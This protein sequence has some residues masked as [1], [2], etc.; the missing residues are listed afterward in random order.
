[1]SGAVA[2]WFSYIVVKPYGAGHSLSNLSV[3]G[4]NF[5]TINGSI[6]RVDRVD[7]TYASLNPSKYS[8]VV[9]DGNNYQNIILK[10]ANPVVIDHQ[11]SG[12]ASKWTIATQG[13]LPFG[14]YAR[15]VN[16]IAAKN[17]ITTSSGSVSYVLPYAS[18]EQG[19][20]RD[21]VELSFP[22]A[23]KGKM[24]VTIRCD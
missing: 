13:Q 12:T 19:F 21:A 10:T 24:S 7:T 17:S 4:N 15:N 6:E 8:N 1:M 22:A 2:D 20:D 23:S 5:K 9:F 14:G 16:A 18:I 3:S 11:Q